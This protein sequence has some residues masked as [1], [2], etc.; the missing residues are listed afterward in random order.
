MQVPLLDVRRQNQPITTELLVAFER[1]LQSGQFIL[2][3]EVE[4]FEQAAASLSGARFAIG[5]SSG[6]DAIL[7]A[8]MAPYAIGADDGARLEKQKQLRHLLTHYCSIQVINHFR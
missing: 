3:R 1:V 7:V 8:L 4:Q 6:T 2:G 5:M